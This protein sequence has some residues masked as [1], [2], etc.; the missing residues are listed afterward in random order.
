M[1][2]LKPMPQCMSTDANWTTQMALLLSFFES[3]PPLGSIV[4]TISHDKTQMT[5]LFM[6]YEY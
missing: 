3:P 4:T 1:F 6:L 5:C 2:M